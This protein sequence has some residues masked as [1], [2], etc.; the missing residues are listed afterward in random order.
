MMKRA[1][2]TGMNT[3]TPLLATIALAC[4][5]TTLVVLVALGYSLFTLAVRAFDQDIIAIYSPHGF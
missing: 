3:E 4:Y 1:N 5:S 2:N